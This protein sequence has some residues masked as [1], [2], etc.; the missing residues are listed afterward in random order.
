V[1]PA[2]VV[3]TVLAAWVARLWV[4]NSLDTG[5]PVS[6]LGEVFRLTRGEN[7]GLAFGLFT[8][9]PLVPWLAA[10]GL[11]AF[12][13][14]LARPLRTSRLGRISLGLFLGGGLANLL[15]RVGDGAVTDY[16]DIGL[17][18]GRWPTF[19]LPDVAITAGFL[20]LL[21]VLVRGDGSA[22]ETG[23]RYSDTR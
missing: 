3:L 6:L 14:Y 4:E 8:G 20:L 13:V 16:L 2:I 10:L 5:A 9:S 22:R 1:I 17:G 12:V 19:N 23:D 21:W 15:D 11:V 18:P 7:S